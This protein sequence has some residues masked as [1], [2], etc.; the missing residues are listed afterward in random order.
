VKLSAHK[1]GTGRHPLLVADDAT[2][3]LPAIKAIASAL[4]PF[5]RASGNHYPGLRRFI[6]N[7]DGQA[8]LYARALLKRLVPAINAA[9]GTNGFDLLNASFSLVTQRPESLSTIQRAP[10]FDAVDPGYLAVLHYL[11]GTEDS[12]TAFY[13]QRTTGIERVTAE[14]RPRF[15]AAA[16]A[17]S[18]EWTGYIGEGNASFERIGSVSAEPDRVIVY[19]GS[20]LHSGTIPA[21][22]AFSASPANGRLTA[23]F[24]VQAR[25]GV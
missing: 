18:A 25:T 17:E 1:L 21:N 14:N 7:Q 22:M 5:P 2:G 20:L 15:F 19:Q 13:R 10:H 16:E 8:A 24:F 9:F 11:S 6:G 23:N 12:G 3:E 4:A